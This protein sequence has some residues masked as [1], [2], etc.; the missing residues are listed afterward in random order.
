MQAQVIK[1]IGRFLLGPQSHF[2]ILGTVEQVKIYL[3]NIFTDAKYLD[4]IF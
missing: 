2:A 1:V 3:T 4:N